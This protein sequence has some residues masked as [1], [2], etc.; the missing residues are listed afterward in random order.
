[1]SD[2]SKPQ[3][4]ERLWVEKFDH[5][6][7]PPRKVET[8]FIENGKVVETIVHDDETTKDPATPSE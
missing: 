3:L 6:V 5:D 4:R 7:D 1:M 8:V 2:A